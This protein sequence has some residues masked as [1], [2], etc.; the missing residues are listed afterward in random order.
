MPNRLTKDVMQRTND[1][2]RRL[3]RPLLS[4]AGFEAAVRLQAQEKGP[5]ALIVNLVN[6]V[7]APEDIAL[8]TSAWEVPAA[9]EEPNHLHGGELPPPS[10][11]QQSE[12]DSDGA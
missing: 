1:Q 7:V 3:G 2:R 4:R 6:H 5:D 8:H 11:S 9:Q 10:V 12:S